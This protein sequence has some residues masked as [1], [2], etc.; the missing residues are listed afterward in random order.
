MLACFFA[1]QSLSQVL[2]LGFFISAPPHSSDF[3]YHFCRPWRDSQISITRCLKVLKAKGNVS[4][5]N[6]HVTMGRSDGISQA[7]DQD[8]CNACITGSQDASSAQRAFRGPTVSS[9]F[10]LSLA[11][12]QG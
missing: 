4:L 8:G 2:P 12:L 11:Q 9:Y 1:L 10:I 6:Q 3:S 7:A 5:V